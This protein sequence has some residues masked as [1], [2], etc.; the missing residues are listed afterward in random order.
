[1]GV[2]VCSVGRAVAAGVID[3]KTG[4]MRRG[5][6]GRVSWRLGGAG[7][8]SERSGAGVEPEYGVRSTEYGG[9]RGKKKRKKEK[10]RE[11]KRKKKWEKN[12]KKTGRRV[13]RTIDAADGVGGGACDSGRGGVSGDSVWGRSTQADRRGRCVWRAVD[14]TA[15]S[16]GPDDR[17]CARDRVHVTRLWRCARDARMRRPRDARKKRRD[18]S[19]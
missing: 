17:R 18:C 14:G 11:K 19:T 12:G 3:A 13:S 8:E 4:S 6:T 15:G 16:G 9:K 10:K 7:A 1:M 2:F 5:T